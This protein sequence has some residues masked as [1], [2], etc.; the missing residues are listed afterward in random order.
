MPSPS[1]SLCAGFAR[2]DSPAAAI[3]THVDPATGECECNAGYVE[4]DTASGVTAACVP[5][6]CGDGVC[7]PGE[8]C[9]TCDFD[10][11]CDPGPDAGVP[12]AP[13]GGDAGGS[14][15]PDAGVISDALAPPDA[16]IVH[17][18]AG[19]FPDAGA[20][21]DAIVMRSD[22]GAAPDAGAGSGSGA[23]HR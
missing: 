9:A 15:G 10:C 12:H 19:A 1:P 23:G 3:P 20:P 18:D 7:S 6:G 11:P 4:G 22:A 5:I 8:S 14:G 16:V 17:A 21:P 13:P 2:T